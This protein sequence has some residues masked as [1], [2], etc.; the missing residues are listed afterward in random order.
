MES[1]ILG[2]EAVKGNDGKTKA[3][4]WFYVVDCSRQEDLSVQEGR[5]GLCEGKGV[6]R[7]QCLGYKGKASVNLDCSSQR[8]GYGGSLEKSTHIHTL[9]IHPSERLL[10][11][12]AAT[13]SP[14]KPESGSVRCCAESSS[15]RLSAEKAPGEMKQRDLE[16]RDVPKAAP[17]GRGHNLGVSVTVHHHSNTSSPFRHC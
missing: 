4:S 11:H 8:E 12:P 1:V 2:A 6:L 5:G 3:A 13:S 14:R 15:H 17:T 7:R 10:S 16:R 9:A